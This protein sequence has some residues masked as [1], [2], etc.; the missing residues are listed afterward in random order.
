MHQWSEQQL[1]ELIEQRL[2]SRTESDHVE[3]KEAAGGIPHALWRSISSFSNTPD[4]GLIVFGVK[5]H[6]DKAL[7][8]VGVKELSLLQEKLVSYIVEKM[9][10]CGSYALKVM[11]IQGKDVLVLAISELAN[12]EKPCYYKDVGLPRGACIRFGNVDKEISDTELKLFLQYSSQYQFD[13]TVLTDKTEADFS[14][15]KVKAF[16]DKSAQRTGRTNDTKSYTN[17]LLNR[18]LLA[19]KDRG[20]HP[21]LA[22]YLF[23]AQDRLEDEAS[24]DRYTIQ[25][26]KYAGTSPATRILDK[27]SVTGTIEMQ[28]EAV[29]KFVLSNVR[30]HAEIVG[31]KR[32]DEE[33]YPPEALREAVINSVTHRDY[34]NV[35]ILSQVA[36]FSNLI[37]IS[38][39]GT[40]PPGLT[41]KDLRTSRFSRNP[42]IVSC[43]RSLDYIEEFGRGIDLMYGQM[44][45]WDLPEPIITNKSN[46]FQ[47]TFLGDDFKQLNKRQIAI[48]QYLQTHDTATPLELKKVFSD[49]ADRT[50]RLDLKEM[51]DLEFLISAGSTNNIAYKAAY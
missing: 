30:V 42:T 25:C 43:M 45:K 32:V 29:M 14:L 19:K 35:N 26:V 4:G 21:T 47:V 36:I 50:L 34:S 10:H 49:V 9:V 2:E 22:G 18:S 31:A 38:N 51:V 23:F 48:W 13:R 33:E 41:V 15:E 27:L 1:L 16:F 44:K 6:A 20:V 39:P 46:L 12:E 37:Q 3:F 5:E 8:V 40:L 28:V 11:K 7:E 24:L 17:V